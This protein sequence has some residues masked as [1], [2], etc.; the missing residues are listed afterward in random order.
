MKLS[1]LGIFFASWT[2]AVSA[3]TTN[4]NFTFPANVAVP[5]GN[6]NGLALATNL[7][8][9]GSLM[10]QVTVSL[11]IT[12]GFNGDLYAYL[13]GPSGGF[14]VL[15]NRTG[16]TAG[17]AFGYSD[18]GF[19]ITFDDSANNHDIH[20]YQSSAYNL[21]GGGG[22]TGD[23]SSDGRAIDPL[24][25]PS[26]FD[27]TA[28][29]A[30]LASF[31]GTNPNGTWTLFLADMSAGGISTLNDWTVNITTVPEPST[32]ALLGT[33]ALLLARQMRQTLMG[34]ISS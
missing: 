22:L 25:S 28:S 4:Y 21:D 5:D 26:L 31:T 10:T 13:A 6:G 30:T 2:A 9:L 34:I 33:G 24:S 29:S 27:T 7:S 18:T 3:Q 32:W 17:N 1:G 23:W 19:N 11:D 12:G 15:L 16:V 20:F 8:G 14:A